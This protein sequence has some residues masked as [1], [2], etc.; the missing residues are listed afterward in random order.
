MTMAVI[1]LR[2][3]MNPQQ[4]NTVITAAEI[5]AST[6][7]NKSQLFEG[8]GIRKHYLFYGTNQKRHHKP[9]TKG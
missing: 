1:Q 6:W 5:I 2:N 3:I 9:K 8:N 7:P 4:M